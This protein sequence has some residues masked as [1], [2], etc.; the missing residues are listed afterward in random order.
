MYIYIP[1]NGR[2]TFT[3][4][5]II[6]LSFTPLSL[7]L[8][9]TMASCCCAVSCSHRLWC[10]PHVFI[11]GRPFRNIDFKYSCVSELKTARCNSHLFLSADMNMN[12]N[13][14]Q[15]ICGHTFYLNATH[16]MALMLHISRQLLYAGQI[17]FISLSAN[18]SDKWI[19]S[20][21]PSETI[22]SADCGGDEITIMRLS[23]KLTANEMK[24]EMQEP[25]DYK[26]GFRNR[27]EIGLKVQTMQL[28]LESYDLL[29]YGAS[30]TIDQRGFKN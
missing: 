25:I 30:R 28:W 18:W 12:W 8:L 11:I 10:V 21:R 5:A 15:I 9:L 19:E 4:F 14:F 2:K 17:S 26:I 16:K 13:G 22:F 24:G 3:V 23:E 29:L 1:T 6:F 27:V 7:R 20:G